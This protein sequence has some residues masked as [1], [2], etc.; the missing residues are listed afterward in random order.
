MK[1]SKD[2]RMKSNKEI[3]TLKRTQDER[4]MDLKGLVNQLEN[5]E[6]ILKNR[7]NQSG[8]RISGFNDRV[9]ELEQINKE[10]KSKQEKNIHEMWNAM[11]NQTFEL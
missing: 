3:E 10:Y 1:T 5:T 7:M 9:E 11:T 6:E 8:N 2:L 4:K